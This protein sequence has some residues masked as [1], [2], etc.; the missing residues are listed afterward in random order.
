MSS[1]LPDVPRFFSDR[2]PEAGSAGSAAVV[3]VEREEAHHLLHVL[4][5]KRG[6]EVRLFDGSGMEAV[7]VIVRTDRR[8]A[9]VALR[10]CEAVDL[11]PSLDLTLAAA[12][13]RGHRMDFLVEKC[14][15]MGLRRLQPVHFARSVVDP[16]QNAENHLRRWRRISISAAKQSGRSRLTG[17]AA[18]VAFPA[19]VSGADENTYRVLLSLAGG[20]RPLGDLV[21]DIRRGERALAVVGPEGGLTPDES[22][23]A[24]TAGFRMVTLG[25]TVLRVETACIALTARLLGA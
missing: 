1:S 22:A 16:R 11:E 15:E 24:E 13:P 19:L 20:A 12:V 21:A 10:A 4:R 14:A 6:D 3:T 8:S 5:L 23:A 2:L 18:G 9:Q 25:K 17:I 7:G